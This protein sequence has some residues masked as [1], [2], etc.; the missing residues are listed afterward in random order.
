MS[1]TPLCRALI[2]NMTITNNQRHV[3]TIQVSPTNPNLPIQIPT[4]SS[5]QPLNNRI[6]NCPRMPPIRHMSRPR[7]KHR[8]ILT[9]TGD[10]ITEGNAHAGAADLE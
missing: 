7:V 5:L 10:V 3:L 2:H 4:P 1:K 9:I 8:T 6:Q